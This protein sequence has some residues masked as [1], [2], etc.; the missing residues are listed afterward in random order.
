MT[1]AREY[2]NLASGM[3]SRSPPSLG[4]YQLSCSPHKI[5]VGQL[6]EP[7]IIVIL[8]MRFGLF[9]QMLDFR[10]AICKSSATFVPGNSIKGNLSSTHLT[11]SAWMDQ[12]VPRVA[13]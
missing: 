10:A 13:L 2:F 4:G 11:V 3:R 9:L 5:S 8:L 7:V 6:I 1:A 12:I